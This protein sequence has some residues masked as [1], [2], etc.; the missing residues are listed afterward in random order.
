MTTPSELLELTTYPSLG[1]QYGAYGP[2]SLRSGK[3]V[4]DLTAA[5]QQGV[6]RTC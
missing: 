5:A 3:P 4:P 1:L 2:T 6:R